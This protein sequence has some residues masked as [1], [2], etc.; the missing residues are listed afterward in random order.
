MYVVYDDMKICKC[1]SI[2][3]LLYLESNQIKLGLESNFKF[4]FNFCYLKPKIIF[5]VQSGSYTG[6]VT[7]LEFLMLFILHIT[8]HWTHK[9]FRLEDAFVCY[10]CTGSSW[11][12]GSS[13]R[14]RSSCECIFS[15]S[16][17]ELSLWV[18]VIDHI[19]TAKPLNTF[20]GLFCSCLKAQ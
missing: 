9:T 17:N 20:K 10:P 19:S 1:Y 16:R 13:R 11:E 15:L 5:P 7:A 14:E 6:I 2:I 3:F 4:Q 8:V 12:R 18:P